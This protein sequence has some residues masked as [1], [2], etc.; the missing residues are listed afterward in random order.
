MKVHYYLSI[1]RYFLLL[2]YMSIQLN[3]GAFF[4][5]LRL[6]VHSSIGKT[7]LEIICYIADP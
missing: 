6:H 4:V 1:Y 3:H 7:K 2:S 5:I